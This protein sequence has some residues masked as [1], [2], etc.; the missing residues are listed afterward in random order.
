MI[1]FIPA[2]SGASDHVDVAPEFCALAPPVAPLCLREAAKSAQLP[3]PPPLRLLY[4][5]DSVLLFLLRKLGINFSLFYWG[6]YPRRFPANFTISI[7]N[8][9]L[10]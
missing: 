8:N 5:V 10:I 7:Q 1:S 6:T 2:V 9:D 4:C 3:F